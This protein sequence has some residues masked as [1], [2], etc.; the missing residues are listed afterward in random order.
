MRVR[1]KPTRLV[2][3]VFGD[4]IRRYSAVKNWFREMK[5]RGKLR[6]VGRQELIGVV[7]RVAG[8]QLVAA[9][10]AVVDPALREVLVE[11]LIERERVAGE[12][13]PERRPVGARDTP[14]GRARPAGLTGTCPLGSSPVRA[15]SS[16]TTVLIV[17]PSRSISAS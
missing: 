7:E 17:L 15:L 3:T 14:R 5:L 8:E 1:L 11:P 6:I 2:L 16:G 12:A 10:E 9:A 4:T 13:L